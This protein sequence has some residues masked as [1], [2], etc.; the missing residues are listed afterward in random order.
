[1]RRLLCCASDT[2]HDQIPRGVWSIS[3]K[4]SMCLTP[5][6][7]M[8]HGSDPRGG[9]VGAQ[10]RRP[11]GLANRRA[12]TAFLTSL[13]ACVTV[14]DATAQAD[15][16]GVTLAWRERRGRATSSNCSSFRLLN[17]STS[18]PCCAWRSAFAR[19][20][21]GSFAPL[22]VSTCGWRRTARA[23]LR[24]T[25][26]SRRGTS[27]CGSRCSSSGASWWPSWPGSGLSTWRRVDSGP[28]SAVSGS[29]SWVSV[30][31][32]YYAAFCS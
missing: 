26:C 25:S 20:W 14:S 13:T 16:C 32:R 10:Q 29:N 23:S 1:M 24:A 17:E 28:P 30:W 5:S 4:R 22:Q 7:S 2:D 27:F 6:L 18:W 9:S 8:E 11:A 12:A 19:R 31:Q 15:A 21:Y 3:A